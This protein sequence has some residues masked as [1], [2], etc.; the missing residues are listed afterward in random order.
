MAYLSK[1]LDQMAAGWPACLFTIAA[2]ALL[3][4]DTDKL[5]WEQNLTVT[6]PM[7]LKGTQAASKHWLQH[8]T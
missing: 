3:V 2:T 5:I 4:K 8:V 6:T 7:P 1:K